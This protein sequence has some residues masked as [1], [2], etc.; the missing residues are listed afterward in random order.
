MKWR[1]LISIP[2][3]KSQ[4][5]WC[6]T[7]TSPPI[8]VIWW[9][10]F[11]TDA[12]KE[13][14]SCWFI[15]RA[16]QTWAFS[17]R[18]FWEESRYFLS[19]VSLIFSRHCF[20]RCADRKQVSVRTYTLATSNNTP[21]KCPCDIIQGFFQLERNSNFFTVCSHLTIK[22]HCIKEEE[23]CWVRKL[24]DAYISFSKKSPQPGKSF[25][26]TTDFYV[27]ALVI[28]LGRL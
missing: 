5:P 18:V 19:H 23:V 21:S 6:L 9:R 16:L 12:G 28:E 24:S 3:F 27:F 10:T 26:Y 15:S 25:A 7:T 13:N 17:S 20:D 1:W 2:E 11:G 4:C 14:A 22:K 8:C